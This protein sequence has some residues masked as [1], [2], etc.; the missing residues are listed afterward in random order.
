M[1]PNQPFDTKKKPKSSAKNK[2]QQPT[3]KQ[4]EAT[5]K[6]L[7]ASK[8][9]KH[10]AETGSEESE[11]FSSDCEEAWRG[12]NRSANSQS[13]LEPVERNLRS[14]TKKHTVKIT[15]HQYINLY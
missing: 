11:S 4:K 10:A 14:R 1:V 7:Q 13:I 3:K 6:K 2:Q 5:K 15:L 8:R 9:A 12:K